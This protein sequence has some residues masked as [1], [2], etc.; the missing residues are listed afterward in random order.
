MIGN[1]SSRKVTMATE[2]AGSVRQGKVYRAPKLTRFGNVSSLT[3]NGSKTGKEDLKA[4]N[5]LGSMS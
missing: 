2:V 1:V 5:E 4:G 3:A